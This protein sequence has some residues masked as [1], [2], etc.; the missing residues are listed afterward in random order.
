LGISLRP[1]SIASLTTG[2]RGKYG[3]PYDWWFCRTLGAHGDLFG[4]KQFIAM[5]GTSFFIWPWD[6]VTAP[7]LT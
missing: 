4:S 5:A 1:I 7:Q 3:N 6:G 2:A